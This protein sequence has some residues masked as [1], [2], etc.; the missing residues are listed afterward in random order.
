M[1]PVLILT[2]ALSQL[3]YAGQSIL[4]ADRVDGPAW[5]VYQRQGSEQWDTI[6]FVPGPFVAME[7]PLPQGA[8]PEDSVGYLFPDPLAFAAERQA[9]EPLPYPTD[10][11]PLR[12]SQHLRKPAGRGPHSM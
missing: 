5:V 1:P 8:K 12:L 2:W 7:L 4:V 11:D 3:G 9:A 6:G 10:N